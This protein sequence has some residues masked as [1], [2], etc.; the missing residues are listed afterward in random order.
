MFF[1]NRVGD[2]DPTGVWLEE[3]HGSCHRENSLNKYV[4]S[5][6]YIKKR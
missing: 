4:I 5:I 6:Y 3:M 1:N 2:P